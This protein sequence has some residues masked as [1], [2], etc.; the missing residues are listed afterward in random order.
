MK[1]HFSI[2]I[3]TVTEMT[4]IIEMVDKS[5]FPDKSNSLVRQV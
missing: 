1:M 5:Q 3:I 4:V 2:V